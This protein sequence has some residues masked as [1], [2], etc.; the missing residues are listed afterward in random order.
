MM[1]RFSFHMNRVFR[2]IFARLFFF[3]LLFAYFQSFA[4]LIGAPFQMP[5]AAAMPMPFHFPTLSQAFSSPLRY[6]IFEKRHTRDIAPILL[7]LARWLMA[8]FFLLE[9]DDD[10]AD[11]RH[12]TRYIFF[13]FPWMPYWYQ[14]LQ[15]HDYL[16]LCCATLTGY[17][18]AFSWVTPIFFLLLPR[19][20]VFLFFF[21]SS[22]LSILLLFFIIFTIRHA[23]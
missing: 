2:R 4:A 16:V 21:L 19:F 9:A 13:F 23:A 20:S 7:F 6:I 14:V 3:W 1:Y 22:L 17:R 15:R 11:I 8:W 5:P 18:A 10:A 12:I